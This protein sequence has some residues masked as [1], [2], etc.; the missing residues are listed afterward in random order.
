MALPDPA[1]ITCRPAAQSCFATQARVLSNLASRLRLRGS[2]TE[3]RI[4]HDASPW[5]SATTHLSDLQG[6]DRDHAELWFKKV[7]PNL[8]LLGSVPT[9]DMVQLRWARF[10]YTVFS[11]LSGDRVSE[12][13]SYR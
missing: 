8:S 2:L 10:T 3:E 6:R 7:P 1:G 12:T 11:L 5:F 4:A 13:R 9:Q